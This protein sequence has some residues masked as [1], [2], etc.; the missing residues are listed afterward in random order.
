[1]T[2]EGAGVQPPLLEL[3]KTVGLRPLGRV[4]RA[5]QHSGDHLAVLSNGGA[6]T[7]SPRAKPLWA[8]M[9]Q[10]GIQRGHASRAKE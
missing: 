6:S 1:M 8:G 9:D 2:I 10:S 7:R 3:Q 5:D 4:E